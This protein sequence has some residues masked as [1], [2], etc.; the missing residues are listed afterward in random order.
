M[1][2]G[3][4]AVES[5]SPLMDYRVRMNLAGSFFSHFRG[6]IYFGVMT[7]ALGLPSPDAVV[8]QRELV[9]LAQR[10]ADPVLGQ[11]DAAQV[12]VAGEPD[13]GQS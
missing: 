9:V 8:F 12:G 1:I 5:L 7:I 10:M 2:V 4:G 6:I 13:A 11:Q 3:S